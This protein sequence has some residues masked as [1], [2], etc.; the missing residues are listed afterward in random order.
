MLDTYTDPPIL[1]IDEYFC[2]VCGGLKKLP[3]QLILDP[4]ILRWCICE[5][6]KMQKDFTEAFDYYAREEEEKGLW[7]VEAPADPKHRDTA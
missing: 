5:W 4:H 6:P 1:R 2:L 3:D 7:A